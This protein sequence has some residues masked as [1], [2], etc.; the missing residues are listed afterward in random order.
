MKCPK[1]AC[2]LL[3]AT[4]L[5]LT[6]CAELPVTG[7]TPSGIE[8]EKYLAE[9]DYQGARSWLNEQARKGVD[10][11]ADRHLLEQHIHAFEQSTLTQV[12]RLEKD[13]NWS[14]ALVTINHGL[15]KLPHSAVLLAERKRARSLRDPALQ[16]NIE[17][18]L[19]V[20]SN[21]LEQSLKILEERQ[22]IRSPTLT[23]SVHKTRLRLEQRE[24]ATLLLQCATNAINREDYASAEQCL[25]SASA[26][27][28]PEEVQELKTKLAK[29]RLHG[30]ATREVQ[31]ER[32]VEQQ[33][34]VR[35]HRRQLHTALAKGDLV[36]ARAIIQQL[37]LLEGHT[38]ELTGLRN[39]VDAAISARVAEL[40]ES[41][42]A[43]YR[44]SEI[45]LAR[46]Q[47]VEILRLDPRNEQALDNIE[48][49]DKVLKNLETLQK[50]DG[51][52]APISPTANPVN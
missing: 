48:R 38:P 42:N 13:G 12:A 28:D 36:L 14:E 50:E 46:E 39:A 29:A 21:Y 19:L 3:A 26:G 16:R 31:R 32:L 8:M 18:E 27:G 24:L 6:A 7:K 41:A 34:T 4:A 2:A 5:L 35:Q 40:H 45:V 11:S 1:P 51:A 43:Y 30:G 22:K 23:E 10:T 44:D 52:V 47:W 49:A 9:N 37:M 17:S 20:R 25:R 33:E 15:E